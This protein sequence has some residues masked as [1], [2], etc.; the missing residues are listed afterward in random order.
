MFCVFFVWLIALLIDRLNDWLIW[1][2]LI[3]LMIYWLIDLLFDRSICRLI[4][5]LIDGL[6]VSWLVGFI[7]ICSLVLFDLMHSAFARFPWA[8]WPLPVYAG[9]SWFYRTGFSDGK[10]QK[11]DARENVSK[12]PRLRNGLPVFCPK[13]AVPLASC[14]HGQACKGSYRHQQNSWNRNPCRKRS[15]CHR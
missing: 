13:S 1:F 9:P 8:L 2:A 12:T 14:L 10:V 11:H 6:I 5:W 7:W 4:G 15:F 3:W